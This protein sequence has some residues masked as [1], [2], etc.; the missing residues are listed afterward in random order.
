[1]EKGKVRRL[2]RR[3]SKPACFLLVVILLV[4]FSKFTVPYREVPAGAVALP[5][6]AED[7]ITID[8]I[9]GML[10]EGFDQQEGEASGN[11]DTA[12]TV[13]TF[14]ATADQ[15]Y[16]EPLETEALGCG[17]NY[18]SSLTVSVVTSN[19]LAYEEKGTVNV[20][21]LDSAGEQLYASQLL[22]FDFKPGAS[23]SGAANFS[24]ET[25]E[26][27]PIFL[28]RVTFPTQED[29]NSANV[30]VEHIP[31]FEYLLMELGIAVP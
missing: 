20:S 1:M 2:L 16:M 25:P 19:Q 11:V 30:S 23:T 26:S 3:Y 14:N 18:L 12:V 5:A 10:Q 8:N 13:A 15:V 27:N 4:T 21:V 17:S 29:L 31:L 6:Q 22:V 7:K 24:I 28:V 9:G